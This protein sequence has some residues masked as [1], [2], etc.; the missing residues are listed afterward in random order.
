MTLRARLLGLAWMVAAQAVAAAQGLEFTLG[1]S[2]IAA[3]SHDAQPLLAAGEAGTVRPLRP[4]RLEGADGFFDAHPEKP[5]VHRDGQSI[6]QYFGWGVIDCAYSKTANRL[7]LHL[8]VTNNSRSRSIHGLDLEVVELAFPS[9]PLGRTLEA[10]MWGNGGDW[11][12][13]NELPL[14]ARP[15]Q[16]PAVVLVR[17]ARGSIA[18]TQ[19]GRPGPASPTISVPYTTNNSTKLTYPFRVSFGVIGPGETA[20]AEVSLRFGGRDATAGDLAADV[21]QR[22][23]EAFPYAVKWADRRPIGALFLA[24]SQ[25][26]PERNPRGW[27]TNSKDVDTT[28]VEGL[29]RWRARLMKYA[30]ASIKVLKEIGAQGMITWD[31]EGEEFPSAAYY[32]DPRLAPKMAP[33]T[34]FTDGGSVGALD[35][36]FAKFREAGLRTGI[37]IR[38]Q[39]I[40]FKYGRHL[41]V[42]VA[43]PAEELS[44][45]IEYAKKRWGCTLF[46]IDSSYDEV[47]A[48]NGNVLREVLRRHPDVLLMPENENVRHFAYGAPYNALRFHNTTTTP[49]SVREVYPRA[50]SAIMAVDTE[51]RLK[52][53]RDAMV[54]AVRRG[55]IL[56][57]NGWYTGPHTEFVKGVYRDAAH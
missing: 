19:D 38:P 2:G 53:A 27:F 8:Q 37:T 24:T 21:L 12:P 36:Y 49:E 39:T 33:E 43:D 1:E 15:E 51:E 7:R 26:H 31:P 25:P 14:I 35:E 13:L 11:K 56:I 22:F 42:F 52:G 30:D 57:T 28:S 20:A 40:E 45:K 17:F 10:G 47:G 23:G 41:Q 32:G 5:F 9:I 6:R 3:L 34:D 46:Y 54:A 29:Q 55:D 50:F 18:F 44:S 4:P 48:L 16:M